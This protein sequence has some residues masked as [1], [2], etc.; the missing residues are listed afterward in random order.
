[1]RTQA[2]TIGGQ[3]REALSSKLRSQSIESRGSLYTSL[4]DGNQMIIS[5]QRRPCHYCR[6]DLGPV[7]AIFVGGTAAGAWDQQTNLRRITVPGTP[8]HQ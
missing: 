3:S 5:L 8:S 4:G 2:M 7:G 1:M 6:P